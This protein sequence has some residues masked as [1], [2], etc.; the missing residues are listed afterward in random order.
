ME[1]LIN[2][3]NIE[4]ISKSPSVFDYDKLLWMNGEYIKA[5]SSDEFLSYAKVYYDKFAI[6]SCKYDLLEELLKPRITK[7]TEI[8]EKLEF[9]AKYEEFELSLFEHKKSKSTLETSKQ[10]INEFLPILESIDE[11]NWNR[12]YLGSK[13]VDFATEKEIKNAL[14]M[15][16]I[17]IAAAG[18]AVTPGGCSEVLVLLG[19]E[20]SLRRI[21]LAKSRLEI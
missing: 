14:I 17:R 9:L 3:F 11:S 16:P 7:F 12:D 8:E 15:W 1:E 19:R 13:F 21:N 20:E 6:S 5:M 18:V 2:D 10:M 4:S